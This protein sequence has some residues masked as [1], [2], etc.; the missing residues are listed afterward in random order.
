MSKNFIIYVDRLKEGQ[1]LAIQEESSSAFLDVQEDE[2]SFPES[3]TVNGKAYLADDH[4]VLQ[5]NIFTRF[6]M[7]CSICNEKNLLPIEV[8]TF[9]HVEPTEEITSH[10]FDYTQLLREAIFLQIP[11][12]VECHGGR[13]PERQM[14]TSFLKKDETAQAP[15]K[16]DPVHYPFADL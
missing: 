7:P 8:K 5:L 13:C 15:S 16:G 1:T 9:Y 10:L 3:V 14:I 4:L 2:L 6:V 11:A 12:F